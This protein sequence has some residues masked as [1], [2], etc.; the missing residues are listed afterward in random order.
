M[1]ELSQDLLLQLYMLHLLQVYDVRLR[2][3]LQGQHLLR[4][5][6]DLLDPSEGTRSQCLSDFVFGD[7][8]RVTILLD[9]TLGFG[10]SSLRV[11]SQGRTHLFLLALL[12]Q[13]L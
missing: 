5:T 10:L 9:G 1:V 13:F 8:I 12:L 6:D 11:G 3:L 7:V 4:R 2:N